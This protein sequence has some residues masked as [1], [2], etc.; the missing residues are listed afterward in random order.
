MPESDGPH[1]V[2]S[3]PMVNRPEAVLCLRHQTAKLDFQ[4]PPKKRWRISAAPFYGRIAQLIRNYADSW[5]MP[6]KIAATASIST[7]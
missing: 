6:C 2:R 3:N 5:I 1:W 4:N 7:P